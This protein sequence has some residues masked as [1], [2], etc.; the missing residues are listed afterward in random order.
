MEMKI[1]SEI[2]LRNFEGW[3]GAVDT[4]NTLTDEQKDA[5]EADLEELY[6]DGMNET[7]LNDLLWF[8]NDAIAEWL[9]FEDW[10]DLERKNS[11]E[12]EEEEDEDEE[13]ET[14]E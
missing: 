11:G 10:E 14:D 1:T 7:S 5:L 4:L 8:E 9:G 13:N 3:C 6:P 12:E 2:S